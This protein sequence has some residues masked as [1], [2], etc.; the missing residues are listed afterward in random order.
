[1]KP[2]KLY[3]I[4]LFSLF[5]STQL[6][7]MEEVPATPQTQHSTE[8][9]T[10][11]SSQQGYLQLLQ[12]KLLAAKLYIFG[13]KH[14]EIKQSPVSGKITTPIFIY[15]FE[16]KILKQTAPVSNFFENVHTYFLSPTKKYLLITK[17]TKESPFS[18]V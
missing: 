4:I 11:Q 12:N 8:K 5:F 7:T 6:N 14:K 1:M 2:S 16:K 9:L 13:Q 10:S 15:D 3:P 18:R 17:T